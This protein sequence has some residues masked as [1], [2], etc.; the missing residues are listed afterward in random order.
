MD[1][2]A[3]TEAANCTSDNIANLYFLRCKIPSKSL[4]CVQNITDEMNKEA[5]VS[6]LGDEVIKGLGRR[7]LETTTTADSA[8]GESY[9]ASSEVE[10]SSGE[11]ET[12]T[13]SSE[14]GNTSGETTGT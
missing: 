11:T 14:P 13:T 8:N 7:L 9:K 5:S 10:E 1:T 3:P 4:E 12:G 2:C 6:K